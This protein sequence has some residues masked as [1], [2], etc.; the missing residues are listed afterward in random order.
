MDRPL[1]VSIVCDMNTSITVP[2]ITLGLIADINHD[3]VNR[4]LP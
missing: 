1:L 4:I 2:V 3:V